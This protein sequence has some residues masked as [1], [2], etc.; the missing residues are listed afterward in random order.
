M[1][2]LPVLKLLLLMELLPAM[3]LQTQGPIAKQ[4]MAPTAHQGTAKSG[5]KRS[6]TFAGVLIFC[7]VFFICFSYAF[8]FPAMTQQ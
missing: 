1:K 2:L 3:P 4:T 6:L 5:L 8:L 7:F